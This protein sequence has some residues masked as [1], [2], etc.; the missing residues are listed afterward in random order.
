MGSVAEAYT[1]SKWNPKEWHPVYEQ[2][3]ALSA[4][5]WSNEKVGNMV[6]L[7]KQQVSNILSSPKGKQKLQDYI[8]TVATGAERSLN[9][10]LS[11]IAEVTVGRVEA[12]FN[13][14]ELFMKAPG[15]MTDRSLK[16]L[17]G[18]GQLR[19]DAAPVVNNNISF[20][21]TQIAVLASAMARSK[22]AKLLSAGETEDVQDSENRE[23]A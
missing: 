19:D 2:V 21:D 12:Y 15:A 4:A 18:I 8:N 23:T 5:G 16:F 9:S 7:G 20:K 13:D 22:E 1:S 3:V 6:G 11:K 10:R 17:K 14:D